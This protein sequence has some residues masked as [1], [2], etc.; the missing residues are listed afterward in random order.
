LL[1]GCNKENWESTL[2]KFRLK[3]EMMGKLLRFFNDAAEYMIENGIGVF[4]S[5]LWKE[6]KMSL[7]EAVV[8]SIAQYMNDLEEFTSS[9]KI[10]KLKEWFSGT[11]L[12]ENSILQRHWNGIILQLES[13]ISSHLTLKEQK[14]LVSKAEKLKDAVLGGNQK[15]Q[16]YTELFEK[17][18]AMYS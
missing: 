11:K 15:I 16:E 10:Q 8:K 1:S 7:I 13:A 6:Q 9:Q 14:M 2:Y 12:Q 4:N 3:P 17:D 18:E 5:V